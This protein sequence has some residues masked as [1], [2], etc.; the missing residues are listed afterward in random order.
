M[1][2]CATAPLAGGILRFPADSEGIWSIRAL[3]LKAYD[4]QGTKHWRQ[5]RAE[6]SAERRN[7]C[8]CNVR[9]SS[10]SR[11]RWR[12]GTTCGAVTRSES[13]YRT[14]FVSSDVGDV[15]RHPAYGAAFA[16]VQDCF[17]FFNAGGVPTTPRLWSRRRFPKPLCSF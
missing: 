11:C 17:P 2:C 12:L 6:P 7:S 10:D 8:R 13:L 4:H 1:R 5:A 14:V 9:L 3:F 15:Q 16:A